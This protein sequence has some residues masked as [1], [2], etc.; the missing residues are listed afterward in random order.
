MDGGARWVAD[1]AVA[2]GVHPGISSP[3][4]HFYLCRQAAWF[5]QRAAEKE[6]A[7]VVDSLRHAG[8]ACAYRL[9]APTTFTPIQ[10]NP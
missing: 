3:L 2:T 1:T 6:K 10:I 9:A 5:A 8:K 7:E 4:Q